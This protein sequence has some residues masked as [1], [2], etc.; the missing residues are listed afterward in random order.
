MSSR[1]TTPVI[2]DK[3]SCLL[4]KMSIDACPEC[5]PEHWKK[6]ERDR[7]LGLRLKQAL[8]VAKNTK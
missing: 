6:Q 2:G 5:E 1:Q 7:I 4:C 3:M 8:L